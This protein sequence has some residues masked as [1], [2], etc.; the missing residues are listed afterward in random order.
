MNLPT[1]FETCL[2]RPE[3]LAGELPD[4]IFAEDL[5]DVVSGNA[6]KACLP[7]SPE[8]ATEQ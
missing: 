8:I 2:P 1:I 4:S 3:I 6:N 5:L 7:G